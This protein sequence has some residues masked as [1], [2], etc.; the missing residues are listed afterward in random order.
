MKEPDGSESGEIEERY[1]DNNL[2][3]I[4]RYDFLITYLLSEG[5]IEEAKEL[6][7]SRGRKDFYTDFFRK[8]CEIAADACEELEDIEGAIYFNSI[9][10]ARYEESDPRIAAAFCVRMG[11][12]ERAARNLE[13]ARQYDIAAEMFR[14]LGDDRRADE[15]ELLAKLFQIQP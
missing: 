3:K 2:A 9:G 10:A 15:D 6:Y 7:N 12:I 11:D 13:R 1:K 8:H 5:R 4:G 14:D